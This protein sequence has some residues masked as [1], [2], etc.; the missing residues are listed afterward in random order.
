MSFVYYFINRT[1]DELTS[2]QISNVFYLFLPIHNSIKKENYILT[3]AFDD[4][5]LGRQVNLTLH[6]G[7]EYEDFG[8]LR[9]KQKHYKKY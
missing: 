5:T 9:K 7:F 3:L 8:F 1:V 4:M 2:Q 6:S